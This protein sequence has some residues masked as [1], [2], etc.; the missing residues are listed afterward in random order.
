MYEKNYEIEFFKN[1]QLFNVIYMF[2]LIVKLGVIFKFALK[3]CWIEIY[4]MCQKVTLTL[5]YIVKYM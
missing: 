3:Y 2:S 5:V 1:M 4:L